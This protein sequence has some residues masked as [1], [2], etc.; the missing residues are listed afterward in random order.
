MG[1]TIK[2]CNEFAFRHDKNNVD[3]RLTIVIIFK[4]TLICLVLETCL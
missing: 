4:W 3:V 2:N 1:Y